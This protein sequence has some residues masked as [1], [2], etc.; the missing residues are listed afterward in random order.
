MRARRAGRAARRV[1]RACAAPGIPA[2]GHVPRPRRCGP[3]SPARRAAGSTPRTPHRLQ[4]VEPVHLAVAQ[5]VIGEDDVR[6]IPARM[7]RAP[8]TAF[9][10]VSTRTPQL[11]HQCAHA[12]RGSRARCRCRA[13]RARPG[14]AGARRRCSRGEAC[15]GSARG[16][17]ADRHA[18]AEHR[19]SADLRAHAQFVPEQQRDAVTDRQAEAESLLAP[20][21]RPIEP[22]ELVEDRA[23]V[24]LRYAGPGV[25]DLDLDD[26]AAPR[27]LTST[28]PRCV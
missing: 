4:Q 5:P 9:T 6:P 13:R 21:R 24:L 26:V 2:P 18:D 19:A 28:P 14:V 17:A 16:C 25:P 27:Q 12:R 3:P 15:G 7:R 10:A 20:G 11:R 1:S 23:L 8:A 22:A